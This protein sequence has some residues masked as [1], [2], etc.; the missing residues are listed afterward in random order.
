MGLALAMEAALLG[1]TVGLA[2][3]SVPRGA[4]SAGTVRYFPLHFRY[5][6]Y[7]S[8]TRPLHSRYVRYI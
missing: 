2:A 1:P 3:T 5:R 4:T 6:R 8:V 7:T